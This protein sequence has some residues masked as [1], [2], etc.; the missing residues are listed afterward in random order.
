MSNPD[1]F[2]LA[3]F[4]AEA[5][6]AER[7]G[8]TQEDLDKVIPTIRKLLTLAEHASS[9]GEAD[10]ANAKANRLISKYGIDSLMLAGTKPER[11][12]TVA[13]RWVNVEPPYVADRGDLLASL[14]RALGA[15]TVYLEVGPYR[16]YH[17]FGMES[18]LLRTE[19]LYGS[20]LVQMQRELDRAL[21]RTFA[22]GAQRK[23]FTR[24]FAAGYRTTVY[25]R[26][27]AAEQ[28]AQDEAQA[29]RGGTSVA[30]A[31]VDR[32]ALVDQRVA[33]VYPTLT[34]EKKRQQRRGAGVAAGVEA[35]NRANLGG[36]DLPAA[37]NRTAVGR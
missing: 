3:A 20:L 30:L 37:P 11:P 35:G 8:V 18:D 27:R 19:V 29:E 24:D 13:D 22:Q 26:L 6:A 16:R 1:E 4:L 2:D 32:T 21:A 10:A 31:V 7:E 14:C 17:L 33:S 9:Q 25:H 15:R 28:T 5:A 23:A 34:K 36:T 12:R